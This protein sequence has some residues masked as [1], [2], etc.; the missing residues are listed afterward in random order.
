MSRLYKVSVCGRY[1]CGK[2]TLCNIL[3]RIASSHGDY[4]EDGHLVNEPMPTISPTVYYLSSINNSA[5]MLLVDTCGL[6]RFSTVNSYYTRGSDIVVLCSELTSNETVDSLVEKKKEMEHDVC[7]R[8]VIVNTKSDLGTPG[9][10]RYTDKINNFIT[11]TM[12][13]VYSF[14]PLYELLSEAAEST[15][16]T[17]EPDSHYIHMEAKCSTSKKCC[18]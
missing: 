1:M 11:V 14:W 10:S 17:Q 5:A 8:V 7:T 6:E 16:F 4:R 3:D 13:D 2:T 12:T 18:V 9:D 15:P